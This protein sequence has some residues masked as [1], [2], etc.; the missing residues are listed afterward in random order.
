[1]TA[2]MMLLNSVTKIRIA[3][4]ALLISTVVEA[5]INERQLNTFIITKSLGSQ[6]VNMEKIERQQTLELLQ[7]QFEPPIML[8][9]E[10]LKI[11][12]QLSLPSAKEENARLVVTPES[13]S[14]RL[15]VKQI[16]KATELPDKLVSIEPYD[17]EE[18]LVSPP[19]VEGSKNYN[20]R[21]SQCG[22]ETISDKAM[23]TL[24]DVLLTVFCK[25]PA[26]SEALMLIEDS[27]AGVELADSAFRPEIALNGQ[28]AT[29]QIPSNN[30]NA[31]PSTRSL[32][33]SINLSWLLFDFGARSATL[34]AARQTLS[35]SIA[36]QNSTILSALTEALGIYMEALTAS[37]NL[38]TLQEAEK[39]AKKSMEIV[40]AQYGARI[41]GLSEKMQ[42]KT[43]L[44]QKT[45]ERAQ[46]NGLWLSSRGKLA[47]V[48]GLP[49]QTNIRLAEPIFFENAAMPNGE[50]LLEEAKS[51]HPRIVAANAEIAA[52]EQAL[53]SI[54]NEYKGTLNFRSNAARTESYFDDGDKISQNNL[55]L[56]VQVN[57]PIFTGKV[58]QARLG[59]VQSKINAQHEVIQQ[60][61]NELSAD[62]WG[63]TIEI[64]TTYENL[65]AATELLLAADKNY[66]V[67][68]GRYKAGVGTVSDL[69]VAQ[70]ALSNAQ[71]QLHRSKINHLQSRVK[72]S[73]AVGRLSLPKRK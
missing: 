14:Q 55:G 69:L 6:V 36:N 21:D 40:E 45:L 5:G 64:Q 63:N 9:S 17:D 71:Q 57:I 43:A 68:L 22:G 20:V 2:I 56:S 16:K 38:Q 27:Q 10:R 62:V 30:S 50:A 51:L 18:V 7:P 42:A 3:V 4:G 46:A 58:R 66:E 49:V 47:I 24:N 52:L 34:A 37:S 72:L 41:V 61:K 32:T 59:Q 1:L 53:K 29:N 60:I 11:S 39:V 31:G 33:S 19:L 13:N 25:S 23:I 35:A 54:N 48:L 26:I 67:S 12:K 15:E 65:T 73:M 70:I 44:A 8:S 28:L